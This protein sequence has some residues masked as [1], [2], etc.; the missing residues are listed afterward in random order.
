MRRCK[1]DVV[2]AEAADCAEAE[3]KEGRMAYYRLLARFL[4][5]S[6]PRAT[7]TESVT[8]TGPTA[9]A[10]LQAIALWVQN[11]TWPTSSMVHLSV[12][13]FE[14]GVLS[15]VTLFQSICGLI[16][17]LPATPPASSDKGP[18]SP[19][20]CLVWTAWRV[21]ADILGPC[22]TLAT[23]EE[24]H[25]TP[26]SPSPVLSCLSAKRHWWS[27]AV[28]ALSDLGEFVDGVLDWEVAL[29]M[30]EINGGDIKSC[31]EPF[32]LIHKHPATGRTMAEEDLVAHNP[33]RP[34]SGIEEDDCVVFRDEATFI[35]LFGQK[36][37][38]PSFDP[39]QPDDSDEGRESEDILCDGEQTD[40]EEVD[41]DGA[42]GGDSLTCSSA[43]LIAR[44]R[45]ALAATRQAFPDL[46]RREESDHFCQFPE[47]CESETVGLDWIG[48]HIGVEY[49][50]FF[51]ARKY[52]REENCA[53]ERSK[54]QLRIAAH[55][56][57]F[58]R[59]G[60][61]RLEVLAAQV[62]CCTHMCAQQDS[63][64]VARGVQLLVQHAMTLH[65][66]EAA[67]LEQRRGRGR[68]GEREVKEKGRG[69]R[70]ER[71]E[72]PQREYRAFCDQS[73]AA[74]RLCLRYLERM[75]ID[76]LRAA[77]LA[78]ALALRETPVFGECGEDDE[79]EEEE[80]GGGGGSLHDSYV[81]AV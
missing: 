40:F 51:C 60:P 29:L 7:L 44:K 59:L 27:R 75:G 65:D 41:E 39:L 37:T 38:L 56:R 15:E 67:A 81:P 54:R 64:F 68:K 20:Q 71:E 42:V 6:S 30:K 31:L 2:Q 63:F 18:H 32:Q 13:L 26:P 3:V 47:Q 21:A 79:E 80:G 10:Y 4:Y 76:I 12:L 53:D 45:A 69:E 9:S 70:E 66:P 28:F 49:G 34:E 46:H 52:L 25:K 62:L 22:P 35:S 5:I 16:E 17:R 57:E 73:R 61:R 43:S 14:A 55:P 33:N 72:G 77:R 11:V 1:A 50:D 8:L 78:S 48:Y 19:E 24:S 23:S 74:A 36:W 58:R